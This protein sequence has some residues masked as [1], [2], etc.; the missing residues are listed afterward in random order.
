MYRFCK[1]YVPITLIKK[2][3]FGEVLKNFTF[4]TAGDLRLAKLKMDSLHSKNLR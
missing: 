2:M 4:Y 1:I 3:T